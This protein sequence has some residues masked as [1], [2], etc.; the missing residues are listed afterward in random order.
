[1]TKLIQPLS[2]MVPIVD[3]DGKPTAQFARVLQKLSV[4]SNLTAVNGKIDVAAIATHM[5]LAN[6][7]AG[8]ATPTACSISDI[9]DFI[10]TTR[11]SVIF[12]GVSGWQALAPGTSG[13]VLQTNGAGA[14]PTWAASS[15]GGLNPYM[16]VPAFRGNSGQIFSFA[17]CGGHFVIIQ[18]NCSIKNVVVYAAV[19]NAA[20]QVRPAIYSID[21]SGNFN[22]LLAQGSL[23]TGVTYGINTLALTAPLTVTKG[24]PLWV[25]VQVLVSNLNIAATETVSGGYFAAAG[26]LP[27]TAPTGNYGALG[28]AVWPEVA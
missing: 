14:D 18:A 23:I 25:C 16:A 8:S 19:A 5:I 22:A 27:T 6:K 17:N 9:L 4:S 13:N 11:G 21:G 12:R 1:M 24:Q 15:G 28:V 26:A 3:D 20:S 2:T 7:T 10:T